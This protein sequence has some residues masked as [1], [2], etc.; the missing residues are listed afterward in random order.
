MR[1]AQLSLPVITA[2]LAQA[3]C[4]P[5]PPAPP[6]QVGF[7]FGGFVNAEQFEV[8]LG[9]G[10][11]VTFDSS[12]AILEGAADLAPDDPTMAV[13]EVRNGSLFSNLPPDLIPLRGDGFLTVIDDRPRPQG[14]VYDAI[15]LELFPFEGFRLL[16]TLVDEQGTALDSTLPPCRLALDDF[17]RPPL[18]ASDPI[19]RGPEVELSSG[20]VRRPGALEG[21]ASRGS[22][23]NFRCAIED[24]IRES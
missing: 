5:V 13:Y 18:E 21:A 22:S 3:A 16:V 24:A 2:L 7:A 17:E 11:A 23:T 20:T 9:P 12:F 15:Q 6:A 8:L 19:L 10:V 1:L 14:G 4:E